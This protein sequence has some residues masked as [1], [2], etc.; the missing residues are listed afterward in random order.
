MRLDIKKL[1]RMLLFGLLM[2]L[3]THAST[4]DESGVTSFSWSSR[5]VAK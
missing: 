3:L 2:L 5:V 4:D 1:L